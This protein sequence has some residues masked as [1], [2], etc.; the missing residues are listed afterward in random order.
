MGKIYGRGTS[1]NK[2]QLFSYI[3]AV[4]AFRDVL[5]QVPLSR[6]NS[7]SKERKK[8]GSPNLAPFAEAHRRVSLRRQISAFFSDSHIHE[9]GR[10]LLILGLKG[11]VYVEVHARGAA[12]DQHSMRATSVPS[13]AWRLVW[14]LATLKDKNNRI[15]IPGFY[16]EV[17]PLTPLE[18]ETVAAIPCDEKE[19]LDYFGIPR[20]SSRPVL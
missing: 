16:D 17:R 12:R 18:K 9:S 20:V 15:T 11:M 1:D 14:A 13:A 3:K 8:I 19:L 4:E 6:S 10:P 5:G 7:C 2:A